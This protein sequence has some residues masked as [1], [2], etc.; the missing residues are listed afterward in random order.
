[1]VSL[2]KDETPR[3]YTQTTHALTH[4]IHSQLITHLDRNKHTHTFINV[5]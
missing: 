5:H 2:Q 1:M 4:F 3:V